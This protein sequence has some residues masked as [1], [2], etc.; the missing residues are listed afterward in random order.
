MLMTSS[1]VKLQRFKDAFSPI[2][3]V[4]VFPA[5][6]L[7]NCL[8]SWVVYYI[9]YLDDHPNLAQTDIQNDDVIQCQVTLL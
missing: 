6:Y 3:F 9:R 8:I 2:G 7:G 4:H 1:G 5:L